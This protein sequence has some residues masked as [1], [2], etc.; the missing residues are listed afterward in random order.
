MAETRIGLAQT[1]QEGGEGILIG[2]LQ[3]RIDSFVTSIDSMREEL[4]ELR[5]K[6][7]SSSESGPPGPEGPRGP[8]GDSVKNV[9]DLSDVVVAGQPK[10]GMVLTYDGS[11]KKWVPKMFD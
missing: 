4:L 6:S 3:E 8:K 9:R 1:G 11:T 10:D 5:L 7:N 2:R